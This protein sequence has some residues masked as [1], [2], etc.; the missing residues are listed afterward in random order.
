MRNAEYFD[1]LRVK[2]IWE[3]NPVKAVT[4]EVLQA[5]LNHQDKEMTVN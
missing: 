1:Q 2:E 4:E 5:P 3:P